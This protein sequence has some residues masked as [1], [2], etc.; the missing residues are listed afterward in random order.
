[1]SEEQTSTT[2]AEQVESN[3]TPTTPTTPT[4]EPASTTEEQPIDSMGERPAWL[5]EKFKSAEDMAN[6]YSQLEG[7]LSQKEEDIKSQMMQ[8]LETEAYKDRPEKKGDYI[9]PEGIDDELAKSNELF[10]WWAEQSYEN[11]YSQDEFAEGIEMYKKAMNIGTTDPQAEMKN[12]GDNALERVQAVELWS[13]KFFAPEQHAQIANLCSTA[14]GV[15]AMETVMNA[16]KT[17]TSIGDAAPTG[18]QNEAGLREMM[19]DERYWSMTKRDPNY[20]RQVEEGF[21][22]L[23]N[24]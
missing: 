13:N 17:S 9:L 11:G 1:M 19:K 23:Y 14:D 5:P 15:K 2:V 8:D 16:L 21:Q 22:K 24:K 7:K 12:L 6:S 20:V 3:S 10:E 4:S 18:Q